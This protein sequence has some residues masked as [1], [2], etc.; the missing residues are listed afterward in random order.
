MLPLRSWQS[1]T[2]ERQPASFIRIVGTHNT[3]NEVRL[4]ENYSGRYFLPDS[5]VTTASQVG[6]WLYI[7]EVTELLSLCAVR[8]AELWSV[9]V[10]L[11]P[12]C[13]LSLALSTFLIS[14]TPE[15]L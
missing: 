5:Q 11:V 1:V 12:M 8:V 13:P 14:Y 9:Q 10:T 2:F 7:K 3:A 6:C 4:S 15:R